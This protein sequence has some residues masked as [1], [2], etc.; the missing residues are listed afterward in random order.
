MN[1]AVNGLAEQHNHLEKADGLTWLK[2]CKQSFDLI[3]ID[4]PTFS[5]TR[6]EQR[7]F[8][9][10]R[11]HPALIDLA[12]ACLEPD[13]ILIFSCNFRKFVL[14]QTLA[15]RYRVE[16]IT[17]QTVPFDFSRNKTI[18]HCWEVCRLDHSG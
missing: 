14:D 4:P 1:L 8:D 18:H 5:N 16:E 7:V 2:N 3:F 6:K 17:R 10:Q 9:V 13:G 11:D 12:M 15:E